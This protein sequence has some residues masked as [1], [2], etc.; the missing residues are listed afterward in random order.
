[1]REL[2]P[3]IDGSSCARGRAGGSY[4]NSCSTETKGTK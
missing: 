3:R 4:V 2:I 1:M